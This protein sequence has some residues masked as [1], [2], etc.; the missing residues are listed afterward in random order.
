MPSRTRWYGGSAVMSRPSSMM[1]PADGLSTPVSRL[2]TVVLPAPVGPIKACRAPFSNA[3]ETP[4]AAVTPPKRFSK[5]MVS[6]IGM[7]LAAERRRARHQTAAEPNDRGA[8]RRNPY[9]H[10]LAADQNDRNQ[11]QTDPELPILRRHAGDPVLQEFVDHRADQT[12]IEIAGAAD[13]ED[14]VGRALQREHVE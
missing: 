4:C 11:H 14:E 2:I 12:A 1:L 9:V 10:P 7:A 5:P 6:R 8:H 3:S 13:D